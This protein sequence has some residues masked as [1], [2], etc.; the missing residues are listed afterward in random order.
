M[1]AEDHSAKRRKESKTADSMFDRFRQLEERTN[2]LE[3]WTGSG[4]SAYIKLSERQVAAT[5]GGTFTSGSFQTRTLNTED[6]DTKS[7]CTLA[8]NRF[9]LPAGTYH[10]RAS[11]PAFRVGLHTARL[12]NITDTV[13]TLDGTSESN[14]TGTSIT[15]R[16][17]IVGIFTITTDTQFE[18][19]HRGETTRATDGFGKATGFATEVYTVVEIFKLT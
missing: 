7:I 17:W 6:N 12:Q 9:T 1:A 3:S 10:I 13:T 19:Q 18:I 5:E 11:A 14:V 15:T 2:N 16:S 4:A 8:A